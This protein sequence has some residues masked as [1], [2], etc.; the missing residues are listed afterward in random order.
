I[1]S[2][3][4]KGEIILLNYL[5]SCIIPE[6]FKEQILPYM[7]KELKN[8]VH[9]ISQEKIDIWEW[10]KKVYNYIEGINR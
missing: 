10:T 9:F 4:G 7:S 6:Q 8:K 2:Y 5:H 1:S 3:K